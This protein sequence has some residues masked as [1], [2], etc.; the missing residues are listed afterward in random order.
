MPP[1]PTPFTIAQALTLVAWWWALVFVIPFVPW[2]IVISKV[3]DKD[4]ARWH[5]RRER[6][7]IVHLLLGV[8]AAAVVLALPLPAF[9]TVPIAL[10]ILTADIL[11]YP[12]MRNR[13][14]R[15]PEQ[16]TWTLQTAIAGL[17]PKPAAK[18]KGGKEKAA[19]GISLAFR[20]P[21]GPVAPPL[22]AESPE[23]AVRVAAEELYTTMMTAR[24]LRLDMVPVP[25]KKGV[26]AAVGTVDSVRKPLMQLPADQASNVIDYY[27]HAAG[28][29]VK[30]RR[31]KLSG[32][33]EIG[34]Q[35]G[36]LIPLG[37]T[38]AGTS[39][40]MRLSLVVEPTKRVNIP[41]QKLGFHPK[42][43]DDLHAMV[44]ER[45]GV[46]LVC[47]PAHMGRT[48]LLYD[49]IK[50]HDA[51]TSNVQTIEIEPQT[52]IEGVT[53]QE[54]DPQTAEEPFST[55]VR[56]VLR[57]D[58]DAV[59]VSDMLDE[60]TAKEIANADLERIR[61][62]LSY[63][64]DDELSALKKYVQAVGDPSKAAMSLKGVVTGRLIRRLCDNCKVPYKPTPEIL[65]KLGLPPETQ[66][67]HRKGGT[68]L[69]KDKE[70]TCP[71]CEGEGYFGVIGAYAV[72]TFGAEERKLIAAGDWSGLPGLLRQ[73]KQVSLRTAAVMHI[74][75]GITSI[76]EVQR[77]LS[78]TSSSSKPKRKPNDSN[79]PP[80]PA[81]AGSKG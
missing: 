61:V 14:E 75:N 43:M 41:V 70:T 7:N 54:Y 44:D 78:P 79:S 37:L 5:L 71:I 38:T 80:A 30:D 20:G 6:W 42:Q 65:R 32:E 57:R 18:S 39:A 35:G 66:Q 36:H 19:K 52:L 8:L 4:T 62:Y 29:D 60:Q 73:N 34:P 45:G 17:K 49:L 81:P 1:L 15:V 53:T 59:G 28:L 58:P 11:I 27:K 12:M 72:N 56:S 24:A 69:V 67:L 47:T 3:Y 2:A 33:L 9:A 25:G 64:A 22:D 23:Y 26:Y 55:L 76:E 31:R 68:V 63:H 16:H 40:G 48:T 46:V 51:Y 74:A 13:D 10:V 21:N 50:L 77:A